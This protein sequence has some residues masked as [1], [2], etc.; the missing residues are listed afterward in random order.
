MLMTL[1]E[2]PERNN[3]SIFTVSYDYCQNGKSIALAEIYGHCLH[4]LKVVYKRKPV[5][6]QQPSDDIDDDVMVRPMPVLQ[7]IESHF[8]N[9]VL[10]LAY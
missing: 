8:T 3:L 10:G 1:L 7:Q 5:R 6:I 2:T 4:N 9:P